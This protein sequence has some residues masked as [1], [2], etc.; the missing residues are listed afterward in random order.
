[1]ADAMN[2]FGDPK[3][4]NDG[5]GATAIMEYALGLSDFIPSFDQ[6]PK[7]KIINIEGQNYLNFTF[8]KNPETTSISYHIETSTDM[9]S[10]EDSNNDGSV[11]FEGESLDSDG[12]PIHTFRLKTPITNENSMR[13]LRLKINY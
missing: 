9:K 3:T 7:V 11:H 8:R 4:D 1:S 12:T 10:W 2:F 13:Y 6:F 5:D